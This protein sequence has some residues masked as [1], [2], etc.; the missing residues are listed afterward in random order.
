[1]LK[2]R[3]L[4][5]LRPSIS[6]TQ[7]IFDQKSAMKLLAM[8]TKGKEIINVIDILANN[9]LPNYKN[10]SEKCAYLG[11]SVRKLIFTKLGIIKETQGIL[12][13]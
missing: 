8:N 10:N 12:M 7:P 2:A 11:Y 3:V 9:F 4:D 6:D 5:E 1:M 13:L